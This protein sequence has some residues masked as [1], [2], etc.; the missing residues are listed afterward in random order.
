MFTFGRASTSAARMSAKHLR[1]MLSCTRNWDTGPDPKHIKWFIC[2]DVIISTDSNA[3]KSFCFDRRTCFGSNIHSHFRCY[4]VCCAKR[5][6]SI[7]HDAIYE[8]VF[9]SKVLSLSALIAIAPSQV[10]PP[11]Y[12]HT[13]NGPASHIIFAKRN[14][15]IEL[16]HYRINSIPINLTCG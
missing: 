13:C 10:A 5:N 7:T 2:V 11:S 1:L 6:E 16:L 8:I 14:T 4:R 9:L 12:T 3:K 15:K